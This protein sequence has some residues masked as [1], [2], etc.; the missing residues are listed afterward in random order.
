M[1]DKDPKRRKKADKAKDKYARNGGF[2][3]KHV[4]LQEAIVEKNT[5]K[6]KKPPK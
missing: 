1:D 5:H 4:R 3:Q 6:P 2:S